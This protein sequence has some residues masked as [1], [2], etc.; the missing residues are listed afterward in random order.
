MTLL[1]RIVYLADLTEPERN[2]PGA[3]DYRAHL[4]PDSGAAMRFALA[5]TIRRLGAQGAPVHPASLRAE[6]Y[7]QQD[8]R[9]QDH[10]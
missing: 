2:Y 9:E 5:G 6:R 10:D 4:G 1:E 3:E 7:F 8:Q